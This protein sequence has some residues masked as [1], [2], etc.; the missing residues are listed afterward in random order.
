MDTADAV[1]AQL[2]KLREGRGLA[3]KRLAEVGPLVLELLDTTDGVEGLSLLERHVQRLGDGETVR[4]LK[5]DFGFDLPELLGRKPTP[6]ELE[7]LGDR[8]QTYGSLIGRNVKTLGRW[9]DKALA[10]LRSRLGRQAFEGK[11]L[12]TAGVQRRRLAGIDV[13]RYEAGEEQLSSGRTQAYT[14]P[15]EGPSP[16]WVLFGLPV[17]WQASA[18]HFVVT[19]IDEQPKRVWAVAADNLFELSVGHQRFEIEVED[20][21]ARCRIDNPNQDQVYGVWWEW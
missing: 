2:K 10:E 14:N 18:I 16:P 3:S 4:A 19:F 20:G 1:M 9:S 21:M 11:V 17:D 5:V 7:H 8:R 12:V 6:R 15:E 13:L